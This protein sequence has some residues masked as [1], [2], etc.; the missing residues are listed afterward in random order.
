VDAED[1]VV[2]LIGDQLQNPAVCCMP[3]ARPLA[4]NE[5]ADLAAGRFWTSASVSPPTRSR[6]R[7]DDGR[8]RLVVHLGDVAPDELGDHD[9]LFHSLVRE[10]RAA[11]QVADRPNVRRR[12][13]AL[14]VDLDEAFL[15]DLDLGGEVEQVLRDGLAPD[16][17]DELVDGKLLRRAAGLVA[18]LDRIALDLRARDFRAEAHVQAL[19]LEVAQRFLRDLLIAHV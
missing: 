8:D 7:I 11:H 17:D 3:F 10:H 12:R 2:L 4:A 9:A 6:R 18:Y 13:S 5:N 19:L 15:I 14:V 1:I 16:R